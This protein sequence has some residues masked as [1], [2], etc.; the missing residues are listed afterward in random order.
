MIFFCGMVR[1][2]LLY[3]AAF[4]VGLKRTGNEAQFMCNFH[5]LNVR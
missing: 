2:K 3:G 4:F 5:C 1:K